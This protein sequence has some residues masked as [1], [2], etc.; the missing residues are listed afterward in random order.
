MEH[1]E[2]KETDKAYFAGLFDGEGTVTKINIF[3]EE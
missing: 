2:I 1:K 3:A